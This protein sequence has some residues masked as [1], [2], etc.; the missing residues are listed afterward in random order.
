MTLHG[1]DEENGED[2]SAMRN[3]N[4]QQGKQRALHDATDSALDHPGA[5]RDNI[6]AGMVH[7]LFK[8]RVLLA[9]FRN[10]H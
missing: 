4:L 3:V 7:L 9:S 6:A 10:P 8:F 1:L 5:N 2:S